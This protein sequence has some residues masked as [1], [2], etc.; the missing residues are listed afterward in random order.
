MNAFRIIGLIGTAV[1]TVQA[2]IWLREQY[3]ARKPAPKPMLLPIEDQ[4]DID[5]HAREIGEYHHE[6]H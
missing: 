1:S 5:I 6:S 2:V 3:D 4:L